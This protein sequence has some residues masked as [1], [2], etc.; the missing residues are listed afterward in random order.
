MKASKINLMKTIYI[1]KAKS[2]ILLLGMLFIFTSTTG[3]N[4]WEPCPGETKRTTIITTIK[5]TGADAV[6]EIVPSTC[7][8]GI[9]SIKLISIIDNNFMAV[10]NAKFTGF[11]ITPMGV[12]NP[13]VGNQGAMVN[14]RPG[15]YTIIVKSGPTVLGGG[16]ITV[17]TNPENL[18]QI[19]VDPKNTKNE[20]KKNKS[21]GKITLI[22][23]SPQA[24][25][26]IVKW[27]NGQQGLMLQNIKGGEY[28]YKYEKAFAN[29][30]CC[31]SKSAKIS[32]D[33]CKENVLNQNFNDPMNIQYYNPDGNFSVD[34]SRG[35]FLDNGCLFI[36][37]DFLATDVAISAIFEADG[38]GLVEFVDEN[39]TALFNVP[40]DTKGTV[41]IALKE[42]SLANPHMYLKITSDGYLIIDNIFAFGYAE[43]LTYPKFEYFKSNNNSENRQINQSICTG[44][45]Y[46]PG[47][48]IS[49]EGGVSPYDFRWANDGDMIFDDADSLNHEFLFVTEGPQNL[50]LLIEDFVGQRDT[51]FIDLDVYNSEIVT[52]SVINYNIIDENSGLV[53]VCLDSNPFDL[54]SSQIGVNF[55][56]V[57]L[58]GNT[59]DPSMAGVGNHFIIGEG[60]DCDHASV[61]LVTVIESKDASLSTLPT[62]YECTNFIALN[63]YVSG[64]LGGIWYL[65]DT[66]LITSDTVYT[67][68]LSG[69]NTLHYNHGGGSCSSTQTAQFTIEPSPLA[70]L[71]DP[72]TIIK[73]S[74]APIDLTEFLDASATTGGTWSGG[75]YIINNTFDPTDLSDG[76]Y[77]VI[78]F[79]GEGT[80]VSNDTI[81]FEVKMET[82]TF[83]TTITEINISPNP[84]FDFIDVCTINKNEKHIQLSDLNGRIIKTVTTN[85]LC[86]NLET[87]SLIPG[88]Y[89][90]QISTQVNVEFA[91]FIK[92]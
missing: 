20:S 27:D 22:D 10:P 4:G 45:S 78:Y 88:T 49:W 84:A 66:T 18:P 38:A 59:F 63:D 77:P 89:L 12:L 6:F 41:K 86:F 81:S 69:Q 13:I 54:T 40:F 34:G 90:I 36:A 44:S 57:G 9:G 55:M 75:S 7:P 91:R 80:C 85:N 32:T 65:N 31:V 83:E 51:V 48:D 56:G 50:A 26:G 64:D 52:F 35:V 1:T 87:T 8:G 39:L 28:P 68:N 15:I 46:I 79:V 30:R 23:A 17:G 53:T 62:I 25:Q 5:V 76:L 11:K 43:E 3:Q 82:S 19:G 33:P 60:D 72:T 29:K 71:I 92:L 14:C 73:P 24:T 42:F 16:T 61:L 70:I 21:D 58:N 74:D 2:G 67:S 47:F 37:F